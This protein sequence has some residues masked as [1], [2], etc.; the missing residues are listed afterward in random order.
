MKY[1]DNL[2]Y[3]IIRP[4]LSTLFKF[5]YRPTIINKE[6]IP[7]TGKIILAGNHTN[8]LDCVL[9]LSSTKRQIH[10]LAK[11]ELNKGFKKIIFKN[12]GIIPVNRNI[13]DAS[14]IPNAKKYLENNKV[15]GIFP[16]GTTEKGCGYLLPFKKGAVKISYESDTYIIPFKISGE[17]K[18]F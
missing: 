8:N 14:V 9:L 15:V 11:D 5:V 2:F 12:L 1:K 13:H 4:I 7:K 16:E 6:I 3:K 10:F 18:P 17:Y